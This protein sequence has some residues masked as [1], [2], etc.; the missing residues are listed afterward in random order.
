MLF[1]HRF[2]SA[3]SVQLETLSA[4]GETRHAP[5]W[6]GT[7]RPADRPAGPTLAP[8]GL[9]PARQEL[10]VSPVLLVLAEAGV[11]LCPLMVVVSRGLSA[12]HSGGTD[13]SGGQHPFEF[14]GRPGCRGTA[15]EGHIGTLG[16][17]PGRAARQPV[18]L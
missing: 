9:A 12:A 17:P 13:L 4:A 2:F 14:A 8:A 6:P 1:V 10:D 15:G 18:S 5:G 16:P 11:A 7:P 3:G